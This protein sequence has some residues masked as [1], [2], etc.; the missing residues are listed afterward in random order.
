MPWWISQLLAPVV[1]AAHQIQAYINKILASMSRET[2]F[3]LS[4]VSARPQLSTACSSC[5]WNKYFGCREASQ[6][7][8]TAIISMS[9]HKIY[10]ARKRKLSLLRF[11]RRLKRESYF[12]LQLSGVV[13]TMSRVL[14]E[15]YSNMT[16]GIKYKLQQMKFRLGKSSTYL[17]LPQE[18]LNTTIGCPEM[19]G[20]HHCLKQ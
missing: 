20:T 18:W 5:L 4:S 14:S 12:C 1:E 3:A 11:K 15:R 13:K 17:F 9:E 6:R 2:G 8:A 10:K 7:R 19:L 16:R